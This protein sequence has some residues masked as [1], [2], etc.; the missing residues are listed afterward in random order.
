MSANIGFRVASA[1]LPGDA[2]LDGTV[3]INDLTTVLANYNQTGM[4]WA[5]GDFIG[6]GTVDINDLAIVLANYNATLGVGLCR[7][8]GTV[9][10]R[11]ARCWDRQPYGLRV[12]KANLIP[13]TRGLHFFCGQAIM[14]KACAA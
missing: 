4:T 14:T 1:V 3:D 9:V 6:N 8:T 5:D 7:R 12:A 13:A 2:N 10:R 11:S